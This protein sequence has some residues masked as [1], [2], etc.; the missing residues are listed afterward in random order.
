MSTFFRTREVE[1]AVKFYLRALGIIFMTVGG[2]IG[3]FIVFALLLGALAALG[4]VEG[5]A[6]QGLVAAVVIFSVL[7]YPAFWIARTGMALYLQRR[8]ARL[9]GIVLSSVLFI[10]LNVILLLTKDQPGKKGP[11]FLVFHIL[12]ILIGV[13]G[14]IVLLPA[15]F[16]KSL[17]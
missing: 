16:S 4:I 7:T 9:P 12:M 3:A 11:G 10:L 15:R 1:Q 6:A 5:G 14:L 2:L 8:S 17:Q 13:Y